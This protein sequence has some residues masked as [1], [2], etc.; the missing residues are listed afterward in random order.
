MNYYLVRPVGMK[1]Y[2]Y[3]GPSYGFT[4][5][6]YMA[7]RFYTSR[8]LALLAADTIYRKER[9]YRR[10]PKTFRRLTIEKRTTNH[11]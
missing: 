5:M 7:V 2:F 9:S 10:N 4:A 8:K 11:D 6:E 3:A 1:N